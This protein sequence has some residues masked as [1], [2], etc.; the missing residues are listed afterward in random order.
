MLEKGKEC[1]SSINCRFRF[2]M[3]L[4]IVLTLCGIAIAWYLH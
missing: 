3:R 4:A 1:A 2:V